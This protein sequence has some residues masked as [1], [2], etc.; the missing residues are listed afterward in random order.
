MITESQSRATNLLLQETNHRCSNDLQLIVSLLS[1]QSR[2]APSAETRTAMAEMMDRVGVLA[3]ARA[4]LNGNTNPSLES[5]L[6]QVCVALHSAAEARS[7]LVSL[8]VTGRIDGLSQTD[9]TTLALIV[10]ELATNAIKHAFEEDVGGSVTIT[11][12]ST[13][14]ANGGHEAVIIVDDD[15]L[16][17]PEVDDRRHNGVGLPLANRMLESI[18]GRIVLPANG[19][20]CFEIRVPI[21]PEYNRP[22]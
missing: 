7:I 21:D 2:R 6:R 13:A 16:P 18:G 17:F 22:T 20:K 15:G 9:I 5:A 11:A 12:Y 8:E 19:S 4:N 1:L 14:H 10:N 3:R